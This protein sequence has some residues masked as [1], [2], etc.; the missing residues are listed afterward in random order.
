[1][2]ACSS[3]AC[4]GCGSSGEEILVPL[5]LNL[6]DRIAQSVPSQP[7]RTESPEARAHLNR[8]ITKVDERRIPFWSH[9]DLTYKCNTDCIHCY[10]QHLDPSFGGAHAKQDL[11]TA[12][13]KHVLDQLADYGVL[14]LTLSGGE[15]LV[16]RDFFEIAQ[17]ASRE[18]HFAL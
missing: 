18:K 15:L 7:L 12:E 17:Y 13:V 4:G 8:I 10:C 6:S 16:R 3:G 14:N 9:L 2:G 1:M 11:T 5:E